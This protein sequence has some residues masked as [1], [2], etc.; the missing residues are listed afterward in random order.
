M[1]PRATAA[2]LLVL[3]LALVCGGS[4]GQ[5]VF[6]G[7]VVSVSVIGSCEDL[8]GISGAQDTSLIF[9]PNTTVPLTG[10]DA[11]EILGGVDASFTNV[12]LSLTA[13]QVLGGDTLVFRLPGPSSG[14]AQPDGTDCYGTAAGEDC[15][16]YAEGDVYLGAETSDFVEFNDMIPG[17]PIPYADFWYQ[18][19]PIATEDLQCGDCPPQTS[20]GMVYVTP[21]DQLKTKIDAEGN[22]SPFS[23]QQPPSNVGATGIASVCPDPTSNLLSQGQQTYFPQFPTTTSSESTSGYTA[24]G[25]G[26]VAL[27]DSSAVPVLFAPTLTGATGEV[28]SWSAGYVR[29]VGPWVTPNTILGSPSVL[30]NVRLSL[31]VDTQGNATNVQERLFGGGGAN[32][33]VDYIELSTA[34]HGA[35][36]TDATGLVLASLFD[37]QSVGNQGGQ[38]LRGTIMTGGVCPLED[39]TSSPVCANNVLSD[40]FSCTGVGAVPGGECGNLFSVDYT[41]NVYLSTPGGRRAVQEG[42]TLPTQKCRQ[43]LSGDDSVTGFWYYMNDK[44]TALSF[45]GGYTRIDQK[46]DFYATDLSAAELMAAGGM[47]GTGIAG[48]QVTGQPQGSRYTAVTP[49]ETAVQM[50]VALDAQNN[51]GETVSFAFALP[52]A[53]NQGVP[54]VMVDGSRV[55][56]TLP[57]NSGMSAR[58][59]VSLPLDYAGEIISFA[60]AEIVSQSM[61]CTVPDDTSAGLLSVTLKN[62]GKSPGGYTVTATFSS[63]TGPFGTTSETN[64]GDDP[65]SASTFA[66]D[67]V[68]PCSLQ[69]EP[70]EVGS[71]TVQF[72]YTGPVDLDLRAEVIVYTTA[73]VSG[74]D[75]GVVARASLGCA[76]TAGID[77]SSPFTSSGLGG[78]LGDRDPY[79]PDPGYDPQRKL[80]F[81]QVVLLIGT[82]VILISVIVATIYYCIRLYASQVAT[83]KTQHQL[84]SQYAELQQQPGQESDDDDDENYGDAY[85]F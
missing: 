56:R 6:G 67:M 28:P 21:L 26:Y 30:F 65:D 85:D 66:V 17:D 77:T 2:A 16:M 63:E 32:T 15:Q 19:A 70:L 46:G 27:A 38:P 34:Q 80:S 11:C 29:Q 41:K 24:E 69:L 12:I 50:A 20:R 5:A 51:L 3:V 13:E 81:W 78:L 60:P 75:R 48:Y 39:Y 35:L 37:F 58:V 62:T 83:S 18:S 53:N 52:Q 1:N 68:T 23:V 44:E 22:S 9:Q 72:S 43:I 74:E 42:C 40:Y 33:G 14:T 73:V 31:T 84:L 55:I 45:G 36:A 57:G 79:D 49:C 71:C 59:S 54:T 10:T 76:V 8:P 61:I 7:E 64:G 47:N 4:Q 82:I 25:T